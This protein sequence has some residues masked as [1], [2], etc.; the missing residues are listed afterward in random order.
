MDTTGGEAHVFPVR[1]KICGVTRAEDARQ[2]AALGADYVGAQLSPGFE[3]SVPPETAAAFLPSG[4]AVL[5][6]VVVNAGVRDAAR[7]ARTAGAGVIQLHGD[8]APVEAAG[9]R[10]EGTWRL[11]KAVRVRGPED[12]SSALERWVGAVDGLLLDGF[13]ADRWGGS[14]VAF[15]WAALEGLRDAFPEG[16]TLVAAGGLNPDNV[17]EAITRLRPHV[18]DV[19]SGVEAALGVKDPARVRAFVERARQPAER[20]AVAGPAERRGVAR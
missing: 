8:E 2:A 20:V 5:V 9:L 4:N 14:G 11:W 12:V 3:R 1:V 19:S 17:G 15:P 6:A 7:W 10:G 16:L 18:V 13:R